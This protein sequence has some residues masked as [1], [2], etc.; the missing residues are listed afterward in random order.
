MCLRVNRG[1]TS[2]LYIVVG[3]LCRR[4]LVVV[5]NGFVLVIVITVCVILQPK[6]SKYG[7]KI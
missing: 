3:G 1:D 6:A 2:F 4:L 5:A 7:L